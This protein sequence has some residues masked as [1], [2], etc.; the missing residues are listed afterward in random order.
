MSGFS[1]TVP[2]SDQTSQ[3]TVVPV[4]VAR[5]AH[6]ISDTALLASIRAMLLW[7]VLVGSA[8]TLLEL[9]LIGHDEMAAQLAP[10]VLLAAGILVAAW[11]LVAPRPRHD[12]DASGADGARSSAAASSGSGLHYNGNQAFELEMSPSRAGM[13]LISKTLT[14]AT[15]VLAPGSMSLLGFVGLAFA[16]RHPALRSQPR[17]PWFIGGRGMRHA[18]AALASSSPWLVRPSWRYA[19]VGKSVTVVDA[20]TISEADLAALPSMTPAIAKGLSPSA[21]S[22]RSPRWIRL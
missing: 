7:T 22:F 9:L 8:G 17:S 21:R 5:M 14:G 10:L 15:P 18:L 13:S 19:Q 6:R 4:G 2:R 3:S 16:H 11:T 1:R 12:P 20:N